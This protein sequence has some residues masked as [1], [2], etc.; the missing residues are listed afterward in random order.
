MD[1]YKNQE[2]TVTIEDISDNGEG[3]GRSDGYILFVKDAFPKDT[4]RVRRTTHMQGVRRSL[5]LRLTGQNL[6][7]LT[8]E[9]AEAVRSRPCHM[10]HSSHS[11]KT[12]SE[13]ILFV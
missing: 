10:N 1:H 6:R 3:I 12:R 5:K 4:V 8:T 2:L 7:A 11:R 9:D 13:T